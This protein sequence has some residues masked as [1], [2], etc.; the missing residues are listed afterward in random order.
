MNRKGFNC[1]IIGNN[2]KEKRLLEHMTQAQLAEMADISVVHLSHIENGT[3]NMSLQTLYGFCKI[4]Y[5]TPNDI[6][7]STGY[8]NKNYDKPFMESGLNSEDHQL[9]EDFSRVLR[10][11]R[12]E[13][14]SDTEH[15]QDSKS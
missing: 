13:E 4:F 11:R 5:C 8:G 1:E 2:I 15:K 12:R 3:V 9:L 6:L 14:K 10:R 7:L